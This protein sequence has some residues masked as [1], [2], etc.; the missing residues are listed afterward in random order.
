MV[1]GFPFDKS[2]RRVVNNGF[3]GSENLF[4]AILALYLGHGKST[5]F[6]GGTFYA[7]T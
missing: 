7:V 6:S 1:R 4:K 2:Q 5:C 3:N